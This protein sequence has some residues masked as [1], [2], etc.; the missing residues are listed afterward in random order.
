M[1]RTTRDAEKQA[2]ITESKLIFPV[3]PPTVTWRGPRLS[4]RDMMREHNE[5]LLCAKLA[6]NRDRESDRISWRL[7]RSIMVERAVFVQH[8]DW[9][10]LKP[11]RSQERQLRTEKQRAEVRLALPHS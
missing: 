8:E 4:F 11:N 7:F 9:R 5:R 10:L 1:E 6:E 3:V 2:Q